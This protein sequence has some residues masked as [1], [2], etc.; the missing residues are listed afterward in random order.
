MHWKRA[1]VTWKRNRVSTSQKE[2][3]LK[4][5]SGKL[6]LFDLP[7][8]LS[9]LSSSYYESYFTAG[10]K[11]IKVI[12]SMFEYCIQFSW[13]KLYLPD[14][15][16]SYDTVVATTPNCVQQQW[17]IITIIVYNDGLKSTYHFKYLTSKK[18]TCQW[19]SLL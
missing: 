16:E 14:K 2:V 1:A 17:Y 18:A 9:C 19:K 13:Q 8:Q 4:S 12:C 11:L 10:K 3:R 7:F 5:G 15:W 6:S